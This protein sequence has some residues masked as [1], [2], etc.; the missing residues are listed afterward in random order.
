MEPDPTGAAGH[1]RTAKAAHNCPTKADHSCTDKAERA[2]PTNASRSCRA[3]GSAYA[4]R[5]QIGASFCLSACTQTETRNRLAK[6]SRWYSIGEEGFALMGRKS[7]D[8]RLGNQEAMLSWA[9][10]EAVCAIVGVNAAIVFQHLWFWANDRGT[11]PSSGRKERVWK[12]HS[13]ASLSRDLAFMSDDV[14]LTSLH[15]LEDAGLILRRRG[16]WAVRWAIS[17]EGY[18]LMGETPPAGQEGAAAVPRSSAPFAPR[19]LPLALAAQ[20]GGAALV[21]AKAR[22]PLSSSANEEE[23]HLAATRRALCGRVACS[24]C[25]D[26]CREDKNIALSCGG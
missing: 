4:L 24:L 23:A 8:W 21:Q 19:L 14:V 13:A 11:S 12:A 22:V 17:D 26:S 16:R 2:S 3:K 25:Q 7:Y 6:A 9:A 1:E 20:A 10:C 5:R 15:R 18:T